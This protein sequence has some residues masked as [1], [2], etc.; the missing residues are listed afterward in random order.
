M[1]AGMGL[2]AM[3]TPM[4]TAPILYATEARAYGLMLGFVG[5]AM[6]CW[7]NIADGRSRT[8]SLAGLGIF[9]TAAL[10]M[11][12]YAVLTLVPFGLAEL[13]RSWERKKIDGGAWLAICLPLTTVLSYL[14]LLAALSPFA[15]DN[16]VFR[17]TIL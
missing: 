16:E 13:T 5:L 4:V 11:H 15:V 3:L 6:V 12:C 10:S 9:L 8:L 17:P 7:Q 14:P 2:V 1:G